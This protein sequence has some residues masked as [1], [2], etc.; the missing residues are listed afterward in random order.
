MT[1]TV[2]SRSA[3]RRVQVAGAD[4]DDVIAVDDGAVVV[5]G[6]QPVAVTVEGE[7]EVGALLDHRGGERPWVGGTAAVVDVATVGLIVDG[8]DLGSRRG[9]ERAGQSAGR[10][11][12]RVD[13]DAQPVEAAAGDRGEHVLPVLRAVLDVDELGRIADRR[14]QI[15]DRPFDALLDL[16][17]EL[18]PAACE[19]LDPV[20]GVR[21]VRRRD[22]R[23]E[24]VP[25]GRLVGDDRRRDHAEPVDDDSFAGQPGDERG[26]EHRRGHPGVAPDHGFRT[27]QHPGRGPAQVEREGSGEVGVGDAANAVRAELHVR[28]RSVTAW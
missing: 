11:V 23:P 15:A 5:D 4:R 2:S 26:L 27:T 10:P 8:D 19:Q 20:V 1:T 6:H 9:E 22:H 28:A 24:G 18:R 12:G 21:V 25:T 7:T 3:P 16:V 14:G 17:G 13:D